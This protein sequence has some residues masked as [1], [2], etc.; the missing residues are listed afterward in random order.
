MLKIPT[1]AVGFAVLCA[2]PALADDIGRDIRE[3]RKDRAEI[4][5]ER[6]EIAVDRAR[7]NEALRHGNVAGY[8]RSKVDENRDRRELRQ[9]EA[10]LQRDRRD[11]HEDF[12][13]RRHN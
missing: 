1:L 7:E 9:E 2:A 6:R 12:E 3:V 4:S 8:F 5:D 13:H 11:L 10:K